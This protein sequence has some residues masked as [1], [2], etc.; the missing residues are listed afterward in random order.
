MPYP[1]LNPILTFIKIIIS[2]ISI[3]LH[4]LNIN[5]VYLMVFSSCR[6]TLF[7]YIHKKL[8]VLFCVMTLVV[9]IVVSFCILH[10]VHSFFLICHTYVRY[11]QNPH[12]LHKIALIFGFSP[13]ESHKNL[14]IITKTY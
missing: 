10:F 2:V 9:H 7:L 11:A 8:C 13:P 12:R 4:K 3:H 5:L 6:Y 14:S 1:N